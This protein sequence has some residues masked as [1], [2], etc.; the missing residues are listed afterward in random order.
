MKHMVQI[1]VTPEA[2]R[3]LDSRPGGPG[4]IVRRVLERFQPEV[5]YMGPARRTLFMVCD[6]SLADIA[7]L[8][9]ASCQFA[10]RYP[11]FIPVIEGK[12]FGTLLAGALPAAKKLVE[13]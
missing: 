4:P 2:G 12:E 13:G 9:N 10:G 11:D 1:Q 3:E 8:M 7:E 6:L 5:V